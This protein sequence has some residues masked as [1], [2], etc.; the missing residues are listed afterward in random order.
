MAH[1]SGHASSAAD[2]ARLAARGPILA[3]PGGAPASACRPESGLDESRVHI[4][5]TN[6]A[7]WWVGALWAAYFVFGVAYLI[8]NLLR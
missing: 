1:E 7:P 6:P 3:P 8:I 2:R 4:Y 5:E